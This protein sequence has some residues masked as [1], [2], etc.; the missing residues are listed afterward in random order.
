MYAYSFICLFVSC[1]KKLVVGHVDGRLSIKTRSEDAKGALL[2]E[3]DAGD[4]DAD[5]KAIAR[6]QTRFHKG[7]YA[8]NVA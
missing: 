3:L 2:G 5:S 4:E 7:N 1:S 8:L 6:R